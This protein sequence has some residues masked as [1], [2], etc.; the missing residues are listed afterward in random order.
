MPSPC[1]LFVVE[2]PH[3]FCECGFF[4]SPR[5][6]IVSIDTMKFQG[7]TLEIAGTGWLGTVLIQPVV[8]DI[9]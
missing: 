3:S 7:L 8:L 1:F 9:L 5:G 6:W 4:F 2:L